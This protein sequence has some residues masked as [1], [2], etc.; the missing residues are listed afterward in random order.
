MYVV[1]H[2][3]TGGRIA[4]S[5][6]A[7][8]SVKGCCHDN[9]FCAARWRQVSIRSVY[10]L[11]WHFTTD[12]NIIMPILALTSA[13]IPLHVTKFRKLWCS[14]PW[15]LFAYLHGWVGAHMA[16][17]RMFLMFPPECLYRSS[18]NCQEIYRV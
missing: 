8:T 7:L 3:T 10:C 18:P 1:R 14:N 11:C 2:S 12:G 9:Q 15:K 5:I 17:I 13:M 16:K 6:V 4:T